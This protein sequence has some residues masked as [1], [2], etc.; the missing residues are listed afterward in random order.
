MWVSEWVGTMWCGFY[1]WWSQIMVINS[2][3]WFNIENDVGCWFLAEVCTLVIVILV[4]FEVLF[5]RMN[6]CRLYQVSF[7]TYY[8]VFCDWWAAWLLVMCLSFGISFFD[9]LSSLTRT[10][11]EL[12]C[13]FLTCCQPGV[14]C[15]REQY[16]ECPS[17]DNR[18]KA[19]ESKNSIVF[20]VLQ[21]TWHWIFLMH[22]KPFHLLYLQHRALFFL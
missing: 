8:H 12:A 18:R 9:I 6:H 21:L 22:K 13:F 7:K 16:T 3:G 10:L 1:I 17:L 4:V 2:Y 20:C 11:I 5:T 15:H 19:K 14:V